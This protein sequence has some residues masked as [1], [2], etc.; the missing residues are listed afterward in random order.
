V[1]ATSR[2]ALGIPG[3]QV[4][5]LRSLAVP[6]PGTSLDQLNNVEATRL[7]LE[8]AQATGAPV[9][10]GPRDGEAIIE[11]CRRLDGIPLAIELAAA[12]VVALS[13]TEIAAHLDE[14]FRLLTGGRR[15][16]LE[17]HHTLR[18]AVDWSY[19]LL[20]GSERAVF[21]RLGVFPGTSTSL[22]R[23]PWP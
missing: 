16:A 12:R 8:R 1:L 4:I 7:F 11:I 13:P 2:E 23:S 15:A 10:Y 5:R 18:A 14:R 17:R 6:A 21:D 22:A 3:E 20:D 9:A 19:S